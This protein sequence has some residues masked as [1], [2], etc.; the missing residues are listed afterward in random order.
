[1]P[2]DWTRFSA[3]LEAYKAYAL[4]LEKTI[5]SFLSFR[6]DSPASSAGELAGIPFAVKDNIAVEGFPLTCGSK[7]LADVISPYDATVVA[8]IK[9]AG[10][11]V[12]GKTNLDEFGMGSSTENSA[13]GRTSNPWDATRVAGGSSRCSNG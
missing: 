8:R 13:L 9:A 3:K 10:A 11:H 7:M 2:S 6:P 1:M 4:P 12:I 5:G